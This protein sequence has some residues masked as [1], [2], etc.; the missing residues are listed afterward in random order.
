MK[1]GLILCESLFLERHNNSRKITFKFFIRKPF[2]T[3][4]IKFHNSQKIILNSPLE[5]KYKPL[6]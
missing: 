1:L 5:F 4:S 6:F 2:L 3:L